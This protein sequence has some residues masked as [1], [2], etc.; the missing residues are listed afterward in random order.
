M[1][2]LKP[3]INARLHDLTHSPVGL[4]Q[5]NGG[6]TDSSGNGFTLTVESG[7]ERYSQ[8]PGGIQGFYFDGST[9]LYRSAA[10]AT[11]R[12]LGDMT[13]ELLCEWIDSPPGTSPNSNVVVVTHVGLQ[14]SSLEVENTLYR[15]GA[16]PTLGLRYFAEQGAGG[17]ILHDTVDGAGQSLQ[18]IAMVRSSD[19]VTFYLNGQALSATSTTLA[20][21]TGGGNGR[22]R[23]GAAQGLVGP[24]KAVVSS[25]KVVASALTAQQVADEYG[26]TLG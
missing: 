11:L 21:P 15:L 17:S 16:A 23:I 12:I 24:C 3:A 18:H 1:T 22:F 2:F 5:L 8:L 25:V 14:A 10:E 9:N 13:I 26:R 7:T 19:D 6:L 4:W 20:A